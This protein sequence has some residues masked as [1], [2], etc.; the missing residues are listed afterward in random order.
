MF[1]QKILLSAG[2]LLAHLDT[3]VA[4]CEPGPAGSVVLPQSLLLKK[5]TVVSLLPV[6]EVLPFRTGEPVAICP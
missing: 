2:F 3:S 6:G 1:K 5:N 4:S